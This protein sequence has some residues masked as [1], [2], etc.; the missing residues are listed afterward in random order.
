[1]SGIGV[2]SR[3][4]NVIYLLILLYT[5]ISCLFKFIFLQS[6]YKL[7]LILCNKSV[8]AVSVK[9]YLEF[10]TKKKQ[11]M[12]FFIKKSPIKQVFEKNNYKK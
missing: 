5:I 3:S 1:M 4:V 12:Q 7:L 11:F 10:Y 8:L 2:V 9:F 6:G